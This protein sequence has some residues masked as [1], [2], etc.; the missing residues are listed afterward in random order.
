MPSPEMSEVDC[1]MEPMA[2]RWQS[3]FARFTPG[4]KDSMNKHMKYWDILGGRHPE[5]L[6]VYARLSRD[7]WTT[8]VCRRLAYVTPVHQWRCRMSQ[9]SYDVRV[10]RLSELMQ[11]LRSF[12]HVLD[13]QSLLARALCGSEPPKLRDQPAHA[14][15][16]WELQQVDSEWTL[17]QLRIEE[18][19]RR[20][21]LLQHFDT[22]LGPWPTCRAHTLEEEEAWLRQHLAYQ[23]DYA[24]Q[25]IAW[26]QTP[27]LQ[28]SQPEWA[29]GRDWKPQPRQ[30]TPPPKREPPPPPP[31]PPLPTYEQQLRSRAAWSPDLAW[32]I[33]EGVE[34]LMVPGHPCVVCR[35]PDRPVKHCH[36]CYKFTCEMCT[37]SCHLP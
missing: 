16:R 8:A 18:F 15:W 14:Q 17:Q 22:Q 31:P 19:R 35:R 5:V 37:Q 21:Q 24:D 10:Q 36:L 33:E 9:W 30:P 25:R 12:R 3:G 26:G 13:L 32:E 29:G 27:D 20:L 28:M 7:C 2:H 34:F 6:R 23:N 4:R 11:S 1:L